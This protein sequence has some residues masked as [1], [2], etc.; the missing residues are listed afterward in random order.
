[1]EDNNQDS[2]SYKPYTASEEYYEEEPILTGMLAKTFKELEEEA[3]NNTEVQDYLETFHESVRNAL[4]KT[5]TPTGA[6]PFRGA[7]TLENLAELFNLMPDLYDYLKICYSAIESSG[8]VTINNILDAAN[9]CDYNEIINVGETICNGYLNNY[10]AS[11]YYN[12]YLPGYYPIAFSIDDW[13]PKQKDFVPMPR[14]P[15]W[16]H[17]MKILTWEEYREQYPEP[18]TETIT[19]NQNQAS[20]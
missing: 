12:E 3:P 14:K 10:I 4:S 17:D 20:L 9:N 1:M 19:E 7:M 6:I 16:W 5:A 15:Y 13:Y 18:A 11:S 8:D 2:S